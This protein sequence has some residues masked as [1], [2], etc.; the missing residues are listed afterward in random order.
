MA[1]DR[2]TSFRR[3]TVEQR[4]LHE[5]RMAALL[6]EEC[7][8]EE[9]DPFAD[10]EDVASDIEADLELEAEVDDDDDDID[11]DDIDKDVGEVE[12]NDSRQEEHE[13]AA[14]P[15]EQRLDDGEIFAGNKQSSSK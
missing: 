11:E 15:V 1:I 7:G 12:L 14:V 8:E 3:L 2:P 10:D 6:V 13:S 4:R 5:K 9:L